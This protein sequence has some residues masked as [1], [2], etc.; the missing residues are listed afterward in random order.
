MNNLTESNMQPIDEEKISFLYTALKEAQDDMRTYDTKA[1]V[2]GI[3]FI[4]SIGIIS[5]L[6]SLIK[7]SP[8][9]EFGSAAIIVSWL[10][11]ILPVILFGTVLYPTRKMAPE[12]AKNRQKVSGLFHMNLNEVESVDEYLEKMGS[13]DIKQELAYELLKVS[14][15]RDVKRRRF[16]HAL[17]ASGFGFICLFLSQLSRTMD[18][19]A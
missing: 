1:E 10:L 5:S 15:L 14:S 6:G 16:L 17:I 3:G 9:P 19:L 18:I 7:T 13:I 8:A 12:V 2:V 4:L 11:V